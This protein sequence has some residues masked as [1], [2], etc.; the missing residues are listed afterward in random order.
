VY[1]QEPFKFFVFAFGRRFLD[2]A[3]IGNNLKKLH[4]AMVLWQNRSLRLVPIYFP[5]TTSGKNA[6]QTK[7]SLSI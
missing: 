5:P 6:R 7:K 1:C 4:F 2:N 3:I